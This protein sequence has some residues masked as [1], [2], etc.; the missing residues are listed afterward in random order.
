MSYLNGLNGTSALRPLPVSLSKKISDHAPVIKKVLMDA[1]RLN[2]L[3]GIREGLG[4]LSPDGTKTLSFK[5][6]VKEYNKGISTEEIQAWVW[7]K[8]SLGVPMNGWEDYY[9]KGN[10]EGEMVVATTNAFVLYPDFT[11]LK[12]VPEGTVLGKFVRKAEFSSRGT[13]Y[14]FREDGGLRIVSVNHAELRSIGS[15]ANPKEL[16]RLVRAGALF[17]CGEELLPL[18]IYTYGNMYEREIQLNT[19]KEVILSTYG[20]AIFDQHKEAISGAKPPFLSVQNSDPKE[21]P[22]ITAISDIA[23][24]TY[25]IFKIKEVRSEYMDLQKATELRKTGGQI[26]Q[27]QAKKRIQINF[28]GQTEYDLQSVFA[29]WLFTLNADQDFKTSSALE[30]VQYYLRAEPLKDSEL[31]KEEKAS[32]KANARAE[33]EELFQRFLNEVLTFEDQQ[34]LDYAWNRLYNGWSDINYKRIPVGFEVSARFKSGLLQI[35][36]IQREGVAF[37]QATGSGIIAFDVG[38]GKTMTAII[39]L[40]NELMQGKCKRPLIVVPN[41][42]YDKWIREIIGYTDPRTKEF[43][44]GVLS[45]TGVTIND[46]FNLGSD[47]TGSIQLN[48]AVP[49]K[50]ITLVSYEGFK[51]IGFSEE[52]IDGLL[53]ELLDVLYQTTPLT[54]REEELRMQKMRQMVGVGLKETVCDIDVVGFDYIVIDEAHRCKNVFDKVASD[55]DGKARYKIFGA[56]SET[57]IKAFLLCNYLQRKFGRS[58]MLLTATPFTNSPLEI[59]SML[60]LVAYEYMLINNLKDIKRFFDLFVLPTVE[61]VADYKEEIVEKEVIKSFNNKLVLQKLIYNH[62]N[63][64]TGEEAGVRRPCK[65]NLPRVNENVNGNVRPLKP[66]QQVLTY[67]RM[68]ELQR[69][70]QNRIVAA[71]NEAALTRKFVDVLGMLSDSLNN[72]ISPY[73]YR[74]YGIEL[75]YLTFINDSPKIKYVMECIR[76]VKEW[77]DQ[78]DQPV[79]GQ[80]VYMNRGKEFFPF[81]QEYL[82]NEAG[83]KAQV[84]YTVTNERGRQR[85][86]KISEV[87]IIS[88]DISENRKEMI[89]DAF[90][91]GI[92]KVVIGTATIREGIDLQKYCT[93]IYPISIDWNPTDFRQ[94]EGRGWRQGNVFGYVR[95]AMPLVQDSMDVFVFQ[96]LEEKTF[97][98]NDLWYRGGRGNVLDLESLDPQEVKMALITD[99]D[100]LVKLF[101]DEEKKQMDREYRKVS[102]AVKTLEDT[103]NDI[104][105][106]FHLRDIVLQSIRTFYEELLR[107]SVFDSHPNPTGMKDTAVEL[108][109]RKKKL[110]KATELT[111]EL[112]KIIQS[113]TFEDKDILSVVR[114]IENNAHEYGLR[115]E[116]SYQ[117]NAFKEYVSKVRKTEK[118]LLKPKGYTIE[119]D[120]DQVIERYR[121]EVAAVQAK[122]GIYMLDAEGNRVGEKD[123]VRWQQL[124]GEVK[125]KKS[126]MNIE[127]KTV[128]E[129]VREFARLN[130]LMAFRQQDVLSTACYLPTPQ[131]AEKVV[132]QAESSKRRR[133][134][135]AQGKASR[136]ARVLILKLKLLKL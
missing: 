14:V 123:S 17:Y 84:D 46:W 130:Y 26:T 30:I 41:P 52:V 31:S 68:T 98:I 37:M 103:R 49:E 55:E 65:I 62:I 69:E 86:Y 100:R 83:F 39:N 122:A 18:P 34:K 127:G 54:P 81:L 80:I 29:K 32:I 77:H 115:L 111:K 107:H 11:E 7:Y 45:H 56:Q 67:L 75:D 97:R 114:R 91:E 102:A 43:V 128:E 118:T 126:A 24:S 59:Y 8:R 47:I 64:K 104:Q 106:Y 133:D 33:G 57:G 89:K 95:V 12:T 51:R 92:V 121:Q 36:P 10:N 101:F 25:I 108:Q 82:I 5:E 58:T 71:L 134:A 15:R 113:T 76:S 72:A 116:S 13:C 124:I 99:V 40:A 96:K 2:G 44:P 117:V 132:Q 136:K 21:R 112:E 42:T 125:Q 135:E 53:K 63:Y 38:V 16:D 48:E 74:N 27:Q 66:D 131:E 109:E 19:D 23:T 9:L 35:T 79:S 4:Y 22:I 93:C 94:L 70:N 88:S 129:R 6:V 110:E 50:S 3:Y 61:F 120:L 73:L 1:G 119:S 78:H 87:E 105:R 85:T 90:L 60:S 20:Q 28:D